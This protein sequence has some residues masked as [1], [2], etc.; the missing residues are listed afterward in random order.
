MFVEET[1]KHCHSASMCSVAIFNVV[2]WRE[3][4]YKL[5][6][7]ATEYDLNVAKAADVFSV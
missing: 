2:C 3:M 4:H 5:T 6:Q 7:F 1:N